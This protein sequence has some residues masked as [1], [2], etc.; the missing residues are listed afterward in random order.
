MRTKFPVFDLHCDTA[1]E[2]SEQNKPLSQN[3]L[4]ID[5][6]REASLLSHTQVYS[7][8]CVCDRRGDALT[9][10]EA[11]EKFTKALFNFYTEL[12]L[13]TD[14][15]KLCRSTEDLLEATQTGKHAVFLSLEGPEVIGC[16]PGRLEELK[17]LGFV[18]TTLTWN[19]ANLLAGSHKTGEGLTPEGKAF[20]RRAQELGILIDVSHL[21][22]QAFWDLCDISYAPIV[23]SH[24][25]SRAVCDH[26][27]NLTDRQFK[28]ICNFDGLVGINLYTPFLTEAKTASFDD[29]RRHIDHFLELGGKH[30]IALGGDLDGC[31]SFPEG[32]TG[33]DSYNALG[34][35]L[36]EGGLDEQL[37]LNVMNNNAARFFLQYF[38]KKHVGEFLQMDPLTRDLE[39]IDLN[40]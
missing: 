20:V 34:R 15:H 7:F 1:L 2:L 14:T 40:K 27:R 23:A 12:S 13:H 17:D 24:S 28:T 11:E 19:H 8:C 26:S 38:Q 36:V 37:V 31:D 39:G 30:H 18:M 35:S 10:P 25:N 33:I 21:S 9:I 4:H 3:D 32:F 22:E 29:V 16:D 6:A 5:L